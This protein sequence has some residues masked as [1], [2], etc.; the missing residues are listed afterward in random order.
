MAIIVAIITGLLILPSLPTKHTAVDFLY[1]CLPAYKAV[2]L[3]VLYC[4]CL[5]VHILLVIKGF[6]V[7]KF[8]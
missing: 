1:A 5:P 3:S 2:S 7:Y 4:V 8:L 6:Y